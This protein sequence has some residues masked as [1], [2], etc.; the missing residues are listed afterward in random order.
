MFDL[1]K[2]TLEFLKQWFH[3]PPGSPPE[4]SG[5]IADSHQVCDYCRG[6]GLSEKQKPRDIPIPS[7]YREYIPPV[8]LHHTKPCPKCLGRGF[9]EQDDPQ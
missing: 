7:R 6:T 3:I 1:I 5:K 4:S 8:A 9:I 2:K